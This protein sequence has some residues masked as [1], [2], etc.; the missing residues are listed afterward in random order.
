MKPYTCLELSLL[1][2]A[3]TVAMAIMTA[4]YIWVMM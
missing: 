1:F 3:G 2:L 4:A